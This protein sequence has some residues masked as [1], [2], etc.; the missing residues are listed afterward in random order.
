MEVSFETALLF[1]VFLFM[2]FSFVIFNKRTKLKRKAWEEKIYKQV[3]DALEKNEKRAGL[4]AIAMA[5]SNGSVD[6]CKSL[7]VKYCVQSII[8]EHEILNTVRL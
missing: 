4:W 2:I 7:Y 8:S 5:E 1:I 6:V 3:V